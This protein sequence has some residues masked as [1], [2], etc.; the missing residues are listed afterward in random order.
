VFVHPQKAYHEWQPDVVHFHTVH[1]ALGLPVLEWAQGAGITHC[2]SLHDYW[3][4]CSDRMLMKHGAQMDCTKGDSCA[5]V[6]GVCDEQ[7]A[8]EP[9]EPAVAALVNGAHP[10]TFNPYSAAI[11]ERNGIHIDAVIPHGIHTGVFSPE[12]GERVPGRVITVSAWPRYNTKGMH[13]LKRASRKAGVKVTLVSGVPRERVR[14]ELRK[15]AVFV[16]PSCYQET[17][18]LCLTEA[19][20]TGC[21][22]I[23][24]DVAGPRYQMEQSRAG[25][26]FPNGDS[27][28]LAACLT[29]LTANDELAQALGRQGRTWALKHATLERMGR[30]YEAY[31]RRLI[32]GA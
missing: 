10:I 17:W 28:A 21:A 30:D 32:N 24:S 7:C 4:F 8:C 27:S 26:L 9:S 12:V 5:A 14:D 3:P 11:F 19:L 20:S 23:A 13:I 15:A 1:V 18:G 31:Y 22:C 16:F 2:L 25:L 29:R 6:D